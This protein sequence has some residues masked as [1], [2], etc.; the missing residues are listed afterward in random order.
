MSY[1]SGLEKKGVATLQGLRESDPSAGSAAS[2][3]PRA[4]P[5]G[6][7]PSPRRAEPRGPAHMPP[8]VPLLY[9]QKMVPMAFVEGLAAQLPA[10]PAP[11]LLFPSSSWNPDPGGYI[12]TGV[13]PMSPA[14]SQST[15]QMDRQRMQMFAQQTMTASQPTP[16]PQTVF[17]PRPTTHHAPAPIVVPQHTSQQALS[18][19]AFAAGAYPVFA[20]SPAGAPLRTSPA[21]P[22][23]AGA[24]FATPSVLTPIGT[25]LLS[26]PV[27]PIG[28]G[29][30][31][32]GCGW[33]TH[34]MPLS[35]SGP[36]ALVAWVPRQSWPGVVPQ[37][38][39]S[40][41]TP[42]AAYPVQPLPIRAAVDF[43]SIPFVPKAPSQKP[44]PHP[45]GPIRKRQRGKHGWSSEEDA[46]ILAYVQREGTRWCVIAE[47][48]NGRTDDAVRNRYLR[49]V[50]KDEQQ[51]SH[52]RGG[53]MWTAEEDALILDGVARFGQRWRTIVELLPGRTV[54]AVRNRYLRCES[55][56]RTEFSGG[57][58]A[59]Q[60]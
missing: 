59:P 46:A 2:A 12:A 33:A 25:A 51:I 8:P 1:T 14:L 31:P 41:A 21:Q 35:S 19:P 37:T 47:F 4:A 6:W 28:T 22:L 36:I 57:G 38:V 54:N 9:G 24:T 39:R 55:Q 16:H 44:F 3:A 11:L 17:S 27:Q 34:P 53:D 48:L 40:E 5:L 60:G 42:L 45:K 49:L 23:G 26:S 50:K 30:S 56:A 43:G 32:S 13:S 58:R 18:S 52:L 10:P 20:L 15:A 29:A 7:S